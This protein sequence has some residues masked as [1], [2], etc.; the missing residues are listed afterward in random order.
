VH[1][2]SNDETNELLPEQNL[3]WEGSNFW[4]GAINRGFTQ[5]K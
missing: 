2:S 4:G 5:T 1:A 3:K